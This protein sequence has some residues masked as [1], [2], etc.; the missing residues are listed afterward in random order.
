LGIS[1]SKEFL[2]NYKHME[3]NVFPS[4]EAISHIHFGDIVPANSTHFVLQTDFGSEN[5]GTYYLEMECDTLR[6]V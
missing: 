2:K 3:Y 6:D 1:T 5:H 4:T